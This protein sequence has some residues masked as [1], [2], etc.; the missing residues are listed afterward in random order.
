M[1]IWANEEIPIVCCLK[2]PITTPPV[3]SRYIRVYKPKE[4][5]KIMRDTNGEGTIDSTNNE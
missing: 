5:E 2:K 1:S 3:F 4:E